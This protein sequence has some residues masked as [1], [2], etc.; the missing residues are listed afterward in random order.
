MIKDIL[1]KK[2]EAVNKRLA[3]LLEE[4]CEGGLLRDAMSYSLTAGG[5]RL[6]PALC[7]MS[8]DIFG[9]EED[10]LDFACCLEM[11]HT[12]SLIH[13]DLP[14]MD[15]DT[16]RRGKPTN[17]VVYGEGMAVLAGDGL[18]SLAFE[19]MSAIV[20]EAQPQKAQKFAKA[21]SIIAKAAGV[22]GMIAGQ[23]ADLEFEGRRMDEEILRYIHKNKT[24]AMLRAS[25]LCGA[26][27][28][29]ADEAQLEALEQ[30]GENIGLVFQI[31]DDILDVTGCEDSLGKST[32]KDEKSGKQTFVSVYG[33]ERSTQIAG[34]ETKKAVEAL[35][36]FC[37][38]AEDLRRLALYMLSRDR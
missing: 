11:I 16:M 31:V 3:E 6:R 30:Y 2:A 37:G 14:A 38:K 28:G 32:G 23:A 8:A 27:I 12:Y 29:G 1:N 35:E 24:A 19:V 34:D 10:A 26:V 13:D 17:H 7:L 15:N 18:L 33:L 4:N 9:A 21:M 5:K 20:E 22:T 36:I 25:V